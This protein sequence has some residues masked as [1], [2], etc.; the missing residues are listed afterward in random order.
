ME[1]I[2]QTQ[3][4]QTEFSDLLA[5]APFWI[6]DKEQHKK[7]Y[8]SCTWK[9]K[10]G[11]CCFCHI[12]GMPSKPGFGQLPWFDYQLDFL[13]AHEETKYLREIKATGL[14]FSELE[15]YIIGRKA[16]RR[17][18]NPKEAQIPILTG[19]RIDLAMGL[20]DRLY[21]ILTS[22]HPYEM[23]QLVKKKATVIQIARTKIE[24]FPS[25]HIDAV[26]AL[27]N[28]IYILL[29][30][31]DFFPYE[32]EDPN[33][34]I[35]VAERY[36]LKGN[37]WIV[38]VSTPNLPNGLYDQMDRG[39]HP[40]YKTFRHNYEWGLDKIYD[41]NFIAEAMKSESFEREYNLKYGFGIGNIMNESWIALALLKG[42]RLRHIP[43]ARYT[44]KSMGLDPGWGSSRFGVTLI[45]FLKYTQDPLYNNTKRVF[46]AKGFERAQYEFMLDKVYTFYK[47]YKIKYV[48]IDGSQVEFIKSFKAK[49]GEDPEYE[50]YIDRAEKF[51]SPVS[52]YMD[53]IPLLNQ[54]VG[55]QLIDDAKYWM[56]KSKTI[57]IDENNASELSSDMRVAKQKEDGKLD[58]KEAN[59]TLDVL[60]SFNYA[61][62][63]F[64]HR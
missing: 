61:M 14:G 10:P 25:H 32:P 60:E 7:L 33:N 64:K 1:G 57:A 19:P 15:L 21:Y 37:P 8:D 23:M 30:E 9:G 51:G 28:P 56:G 12:V 42:E 55:K 31:A 18:Y 22:R 6:E 58:K 2:T 46:F 39:A 3:T 36:I 34:P 43:V 48:F 50:Q 24:A 62:Q 29:D 54:T 4:I 41:R 38:L 59:S 53:V 11:Y 16:F 44:P 49:I 40:R 63:Y 45:E 17:Y 26:R 35:K 27:T 52:A 20:I 5:T 13:K 47:D